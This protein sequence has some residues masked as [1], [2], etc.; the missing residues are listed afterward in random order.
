[1]VT[2]PFPTSAAER[3][4]Y[5]ASEA[6]PALPL[7]PAAAV[8]GRAAPLLEALAGGRAVEAGEAGAALL[9][10]LASFYRVGV[11]PLRVLGARPQAAASSGA[12]VYEV[13]GDYEPATAQIRVFSRTAVRGQIVRPKSF[14]C[15]LLHEFCHHLDV[16]LFGF[17]ASYHTRGFFGRVDGLYHLALGT[18]EAERRPLCWV[19]A[20]D[21]FRIDWPA[22]L[23]PG[24]AGARAG[25]GVKAG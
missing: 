7:P 19:P 9:E 15:T 1:M 21:A 3:L 22:T 11:P 2:D 6:W 13:F 17:R 12:N 18:P 23:P 14:L 10:G 8:R 24:R 4:A 25:G 20:G 5:A 16:R